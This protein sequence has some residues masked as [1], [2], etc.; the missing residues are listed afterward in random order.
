MKFRYLIADS[1]NGEVYGTNDEALARQY[2]LSEEN[3]VC[4]AETSRLFTDDVSHQDIRE[5]D[6]I[7]SEEAEE[8]SVDEDLDDEDLDDLE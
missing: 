2:A 8:E 4:D 3:Y 7:E 1:A 6:P 5:A